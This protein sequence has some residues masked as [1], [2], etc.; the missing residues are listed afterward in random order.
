[1]TKTPP[2]PTLKLVPTPLERRSG[3]D[4]RRVDTLLPGEPERRRSV[5]PRKPDVRE[6]ALSDAEWAELLSQAGGLR[7]GA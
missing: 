3:R 5:E 1:M 6:L 7:G 4:R 2:P